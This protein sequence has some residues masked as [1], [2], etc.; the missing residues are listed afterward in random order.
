MWFLIFCFVLLAVEKG[1]I[2]P[3][4]PYQTVF[5][6]S[7][8]SVLAFLFCVH[9]KYSL[10]NWMEVRV[11]ICLPRLGFLLMLI[12]RKTIS[13]KISLAASKII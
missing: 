8:H 13:I 10:I 5:S 3:K 6:H 11:P 9:C 4:T 12:T 7:L 2:N 1:H